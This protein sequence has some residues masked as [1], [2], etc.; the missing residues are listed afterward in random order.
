M[1]CPKCKI[2][3]RISASRY[4]VDHDDTPEAETKLYTQQDMVCRNKQCINYGK[5]VFQNLIELPITSQSV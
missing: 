2:E 1:L 4:V 5:L 3:M